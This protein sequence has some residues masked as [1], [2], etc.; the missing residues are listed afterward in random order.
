MKQATQNTFNGGLDTDSSTHLVGPDRFVDGLNFRIGWGSTDVGDIE[1]VY[2]N[3][4]LAN[5][6]PAGDNKTV[7]AVEDRQTNS[8]I[9]FNWNSNN[10]HGIYRYYPMGS[11]LDELIISSELG[12][13]QDRYITSIKVVDGELLYWSD[14]EIVDGSISGNFPMKLNMTTASNYQKLMSY[15]LFFGDASFTVGSEYRIST[16]D[17]DGNVVL[18]DQN[19]YTVQVGDSVADV[20]SSLRTNLLL[21]GISVSYLDIDNPGKMTVT[22]NTEEIRISITGASGNT[23]MFAPLNHYSENITANQLA[24]AKP[25]PRNYP[26]PQFE[27]DATITNNRC[28]GFSFRFRYRYLFRDGER[29]R[30]SPI[31][32]VPSNFEPLSGAAIPA[33]VKNSQDYNKVVLVFDDAILDDVEWRSLIKGIEIAVTY[34]SSGVWRTVDVLDMDYYGLETNQYEFKNDGTYPVIASDEASTSDA[35]ALG[36]QDFVPRLTASLETVVDKD[37]SFTLLAGGNLMFYDSD[38]A[39]A[40]LSVGV[41]AIPSSTHP[42][43]QTTGHRGLKSGGVYD[44]SVIYEDGIFQRQSAAKHLG[45]IRVPF[46]QFG[47]GNQRYLSVSFKSPPPLWATRYRL[48]ISNNQNQ[49]I[50]FQAGAKRCQYWVIDTST[51]TATATTHGAGDA[52]HFAFELKIEDLDESTLRNVIFDQSNEGG[53]VFIPE[54]KDRIQIVNGNFGGF[55]SLDIEDYNFPIAGY[56]LTYP[57]TGVTLD[58]VSIFVEFNVG[59]PD[60]TMGANP[61]DA[62]TVEIYRPGDSSGDGLF[63]EI[64]EAQDILDPGDPSK[65]RHQSTNDIFWGDT[66]ITSRRFVHDFNG[67]GPYDILLQNVQRPYL[68]PI[69]DDRDTMSDLGRAHAEDPDEKEVFDYSQVRVSDTYSPDAQNNGLNNFRGS[70]YIRINRRFG[71]I[72]S[73]QL[74]DRVLLAIAQNKSQ[75]IY[76]GKDEVLD[77]SGSSLVG[78]SDSL[79]SIADE[80]QL[81]LG[82]KDPATIVKEDEKIYCWDRQKGKVWRYTTGG[83]QVPISNYGRNRFYQDNSEQETIRYPAVGGY[84]REY[85]TYYL[86]FRGGV[87]LTM[88][89]QEPNVGEGGPGKWLPNF[90]FTPEMYVTSGTRMI[91]FR[92]GSAWLHN[93]ASVCSFYG[94]QY[95]CTVTFIVNID[96]SSVKDFLHIMQESTALWTAELIETLPTPSY[97]YGMKSEL[98]A[99]KWTLYEGQYRAD[100]LRDYEDPRAEFAAISDPTEK[101]VTALLKGRPLKGEVMRIKLKLSDPSIFSKLRS[102]ITYYSNS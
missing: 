32:Y 1:T 41:R 7:G 4:P 44:V 92:N 99:N 87:F 76:V 37:G 91:T 96:H 84:Q 33:E 19:L 93:K 86:T 89:Y 20:V 66:I 39:R 17:L 25:I 48:A 77:L 47:P 100:F 65:V 9:F 22:H 6:L 73:L 49:S 98:I 79:L 71:P 95:D 85:S 56:S 5:D 35:Q 64:G 51:Q 62:Y 50:Y 38:P 61:L 57:T 102:V 36:N 90:S 43:A 10:D 97:P 13:D 78:R 67:G 2:G 83:G 46:D 58:R 3:T 21:L 54:P 23:I 60:L 11:R 69:P 28:Y 81:D 101:K 18:A 16:T 59:D 27:I 26:A 82:T 24:L 8:V 94:V 45:R 40:D 55:S 29:S 80:L 72:Y 53:I 30:F 14:T 63:Y 31:S 88:G 34:G 52:T 70:N 15:C 42:A 12:F 74:V 75:P 68:H